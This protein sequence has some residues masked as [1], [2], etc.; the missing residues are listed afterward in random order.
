MAN[1]KLA[2]FSFPQQS[3]QLKPDYFPLNIKMKRNPT[4]LKSC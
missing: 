3:N 1:P 2:N 4:C